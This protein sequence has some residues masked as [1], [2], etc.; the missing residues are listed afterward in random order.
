MTKAIIKDEELD[1]LFPSRDNFIDKTLNAKINDDIKEI[2]EL[3][4]LP[5]STFELNIERKYCIYLYGILIDGSKTLVILKNI[6]VYFDICVPKMYRQKIEV[7]KKQMRK[8]ITC[9]SMSVIEKYKFKGFQKRK[10]PWIRLFFNN[11]Y[12]RTNTLKKL[13]EIIAIQNLDLS[14]SSNDSTA[15][16]QSKVYTEVVARDKRFNLC[17]WNKIVNYMQVELDYVNDN[18]KYVFM[19]DIN[20][21]HKYDN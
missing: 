13:N 18:C 8:L 2:N 1:E 11:L 14:I 12:D 10:H 9:N 17:G 4:F 20:D 15:S 3:L 21:I 5:N 16:K 6:D 7:F 19:V